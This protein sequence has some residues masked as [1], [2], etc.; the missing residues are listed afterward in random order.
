MGKGPVVVQERVRLIDG[1]L[2]V[3][4]SPSRGSPAGP[5]PQHKD[6]IVPD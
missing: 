1:E 3:E 5:I 2:M 4:S 6:R